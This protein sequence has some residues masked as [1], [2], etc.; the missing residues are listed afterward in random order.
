MRRK[1]FVKDVSEKL[2]NS[3]KMDFVVHQV[4]FA[5]FT[6]THILLLYTIDY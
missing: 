2:H 5:L 4:I 1:V 6:S 3:K